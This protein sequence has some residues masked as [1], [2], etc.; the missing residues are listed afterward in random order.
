MSGLMILR[1]KL[2]L[3]CVLFH[4]PDANLVQIVTPL[5]ASFFFHSLDRVRARRE[6]LHSFV[7]S[8]VRRFKFLD[9]LER[10][11]SRD[12]TAKDHI[13]VIEESEGCTHSNVELGFICMACLYS[14]AACD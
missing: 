4:V 12:H 14:S 8:L 6:D 10:S 1:S 7:G 9:Q 2:V 11:H 13:F 3:I 5:L